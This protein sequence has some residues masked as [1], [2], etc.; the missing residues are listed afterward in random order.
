MEEIYHQKEHWDIEMMIYFFFFC[1]ILFFF[2]ILKDIIH[3]WSE[4]S[5]S[6][7]DFY[8]VIEEIVIDFR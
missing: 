3:N 8:F 5:T 1:C 7:T 2:S 4:E 6:G